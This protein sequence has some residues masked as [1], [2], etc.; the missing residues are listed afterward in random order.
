MSLSVD[1]AHKNRRKRSDF[2]T[3][4]LPLKPCLVLS[5]VNDLAAR[6]RVRVARY[7]L[8]RYPGPSLVPVG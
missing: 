2:A 1:L 6:A 3:M 4:T 8:G 7:T 5:A